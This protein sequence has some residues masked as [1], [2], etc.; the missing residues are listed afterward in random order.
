MTNSPAVAPPARFAVLG[1]P[2]AHSRSPQ[3]HQ[4]NFAAL[5]MLLRGLSGDGASNDPA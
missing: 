2:V 3:M 1:H 5:G 4:A